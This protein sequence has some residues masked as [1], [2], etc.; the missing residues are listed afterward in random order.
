MDTQ[1]SDTSFEEGILFTLDVRGKKLGCSLLDCT[2]KILKVLDH[3]YQLSVAGNYI[4]QAT[5]GISNYRFVDEINNLV[6]SFFIQHRPTTCIISI[7]VNPENLEF[8]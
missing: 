6:E 8:I 4:E 3:D 5:G 2:D 7:R 1:P